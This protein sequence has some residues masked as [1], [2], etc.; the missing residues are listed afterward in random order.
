MCCWSGDPTLRPNA[1]VLVKLLRQQ[2]ESLKQHSA[3][4]SAAA[5][6]VA[7]SNAAANANGNANGGGGGG[8][9]GG[10]SNSTAANS[11]TA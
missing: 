8:G 9:G 10:S 6:A 11:K 4:M 7:R 3:G 1:T 2:L 5:A